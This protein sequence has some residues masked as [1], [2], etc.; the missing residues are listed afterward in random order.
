MHVDGVTPESC[1]IIYSMQPGAII[2]GATAQL[3]ALRLDLHTRPHMLF[4]IAPVAST[5]AT[6]C[7]RV[8]LHNMH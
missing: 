6:G 7:W 1:S 3:L 4:N 2:S 5:T 8:P